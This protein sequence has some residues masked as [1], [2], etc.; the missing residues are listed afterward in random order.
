[1]NVCIN[2]MLA[3]LND[4]CRTEHIEIHDPTVFS[5][6]CV[7]VV[8]YDLPSVDEKDWRKKRSKKMF[9]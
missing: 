5:L 1:M 3:F 6:H 2:V 9:L 7:G 4:I 8:Y